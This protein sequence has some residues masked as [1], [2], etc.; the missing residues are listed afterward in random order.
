[1]NPVVW[2]NSNNRGFDVNYLNPVIFYRAIEFE[3]GQDAGNAIVGASGKYKVN[4]NINIYSQFVLDEFSLND[5]K[6]GNK[7][8]KNKFG[9][10]LG[11]KYYNAFKVKDLMLQAEYNHVRPYTYSHNSI[12]LNYAHN[13]QGMAHLW[14][15]NFRELVLIGR[16]NY[17]RWFGEAKFIAGERG[18]DFNTPQDS[19]SYGG[20]L[21]GDEDTRPFNSGVNVAQGNKVTSLF[22][23]GQVAYLVNPASNLKVFAN[24]TYRNF[25]PEVNTAAQFKNS[26]VWFNIGVRTD[27]FNFY[28]D[29]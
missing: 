25:D 17:K 2:T 10:Q 22:A 5:I 3:T 11:V 19:A 29:F 20:D 7:S 21:F 1:M 14:G 27:L 16:Y 26:T 18:F 8:W 4:D 13:N 15:S 9:Y 23:S 12:V 24:A 28:T 6:A